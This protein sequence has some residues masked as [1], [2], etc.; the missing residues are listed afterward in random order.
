MSQINFAALAKQHPEFRRELQKLN[1]WM[2]T[3]PN[4]R[5]INP[6]SLA[7]DLSGTDKNTLASALMLLKRAGY[8]KLVYKVMTPDGVM[9][10]GEF[11]DPTSI[12]EKLADRF[13]NY[14]D[15]SEADV[16][17]VYKKVA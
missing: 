7:K 11:E 6:N 3:H 4:V 8:L 13:S 16:V 12:P 10:D 9:A 17:P 2:N 15:T 1:S 5:V 14:F